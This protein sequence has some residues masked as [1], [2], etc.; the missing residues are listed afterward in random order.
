MLKQD[1]TMFF[2]GDSFTGVEGIL[3]EISAVIAIT[4]LLGPKYEDKALSWIGSQV[5]SNKNSKSYGKQP[6]ID[7]LVDNLVDG[8]SKADFGFQVKNTMTP[9]TDIRHY[10]NFADKDL[11]EILRGAGIESEDIQKVYISDVYNVPYKRLGNTYV[12]VGANTSWNHHDPA[13]RGF[14]QYTKIDE[15]ID[16]L[17]PNINIYLTQ[18][19]S[20]FIYMSLPDFPEALATLDESLNKSARGNFCY[21]VGD[22]AFFAIEMLKD[23][24]T[25][26]EALK[27]IKREEEQK[28]IQMGLQLSAYFS[29]GSNRVSYTIVD[30][31]NGSAAS[32]NLG[33]RMKSSYGFHI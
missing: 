17:V 8:K 26:L 6:S 16:N 27:Q 19:A 13:S 2:V 28:S 12:K 3:G 11:M 24:Q 21:I 7:V 14:K 1:E 30:T 10:V 9:I 20:D 4:K 25:Q 32:E 18:F 5:G 31:K 33:I 15:A 23:L 29:N 22:T